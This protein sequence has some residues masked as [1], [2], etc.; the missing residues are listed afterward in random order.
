METAGFAIKTGN[1]VAR[2]FPIVRLSFVY[3]S[4]SFANVPNRSPIVRLSFAYRS[5]IVCCRR[6]SRTILSFAIVRQSF[7]TR[8]QSFTN[9]SPIVCYRSPIVRQ[10][11]ANRSASFAGCLPNSRFCSPGFRY[12]SRFDCFLPFVFSHA[13]K[14]SIFSKTPTETNWHNPNCD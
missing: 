10:W 1:L 7:T 13:P 14:I 6:L 11:C 5:S 2:D 12:S 8:S 9:R 3:H 4:L